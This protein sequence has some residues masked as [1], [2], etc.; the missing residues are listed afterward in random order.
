VPVPVRANLVVV[1]ALLL[2]VCVRR[3][4]IAVKR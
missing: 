2:V 1:G 4:L 3:P